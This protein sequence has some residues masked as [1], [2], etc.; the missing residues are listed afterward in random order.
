MMPFQ[1]GMHA[2]SADCSFDLFLATRIF[3]NPV[4]GLVVDS[5]VFVYHPASGLHEPGVASPRPS[6]YHDH[7]PLVHS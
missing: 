5:E 6:H 2:S 3:S 4:L 1:L 7:C